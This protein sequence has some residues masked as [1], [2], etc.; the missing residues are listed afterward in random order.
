VAD[1]GGDA[2]LDAGEDAGLDA[3]VD[4]GVDAGASALCVPGQQPDLTQV[5]SYLSGTLLSAVWSADLNGDGMLDL[6]TTT[7]NDT[8]YPFYNDSVLIVIFGLEDGGLSD[9]L[10]YSFDAGVDTIAVADLNGDGWP[11]VVAGSV[12][13]PGVAILLNLGDGGF[14]SP[15][16]YPTGAPVRDIGVGD[17]NADGLQDL[18]VAE[19][20]GSTGFPEILFNEG[21]GSFVSGGFLAAP[22]YPGNAVVADFNGDGLADIAIGSGAYN[23]PITLCWS[24]GDG[25]FLFSEV[26]P[27]GI[28]GGA[29]WSVPGA[30]PGLDGGV[31]LISAAWVEPSSASYYGVVDLM[32]NSAGE[33]QSGESFP[34]PNF[35]GYFLS[36]DLTGDCIPDVLVFG[37]CSGCGPPNA[38]YVELLV[39]YS[40][41]GFGSPQ[42]LVPQVQWPSVPAFLGVVGSPRAI[43]IADIWDGGLMV[44]GDPS[45][46]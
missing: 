24:Q 16:S 43:A 19:W 34:V 20:P 17:F 5:T 23:G 2:G 38:D 14:G 30:V 31:E 13:T 46:H 40:D 3:G 29:I 35:P 39:G 33:L 18:V 6:L 45:K 42:A 41:G 25:G 32:T 1:G 44:V 36:G 28:D 12:T 22:Q 7:Y 21:G 10:T 26:W 8:V 37:G 27:D 9:P 15:V 11:D 4:A